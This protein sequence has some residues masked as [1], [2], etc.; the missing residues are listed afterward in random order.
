MFRLHS[1]ADAG[2]TGASWRAARPTRSSQG[3]IPCISVTGHAE[4]KGAR[5]SQS[6]LGS[7]CDMEGRALMH[8][9]QTTIHASLPSLPRVC[10]LPSYQSKPEFSKLTSHRCTSHTQTHADACRPVYKRRKK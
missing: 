6:A 10:R 1:S 2:R 7:G 3:I 4:F 8:L 5:H 9:W